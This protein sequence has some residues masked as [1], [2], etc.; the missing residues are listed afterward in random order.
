[1]HELW[2]VIVLSL[3]VLLFDFCVFLL[4]YLLPFWCHLPTY[5][6][7]NL[8]NENKDTEGKNLQSEG[9]DGDYLENVEGARDEQILQK[10]IDEISTL[11]LNHTTG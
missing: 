9:S 1:M 3:S 5:L 8:S 6:H 10:L 11:L 2:T 4:A 7:F